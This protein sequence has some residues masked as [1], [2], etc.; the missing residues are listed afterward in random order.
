MEMAEG[1]KTREVGASMQVSMRRNCRRREGGLRYP[2][3][4]GSLDVRKLVGSILTIRKWFVAEEKTD[5]WKWIT[6]QF[7]HC[8]L[9]SFPSVVLGHDGRISWIRSGL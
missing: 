4:L 8:T 7:V 9:L 5:P 6:L 3:G 1:A 2:A